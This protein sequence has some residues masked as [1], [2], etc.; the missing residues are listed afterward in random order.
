MG[1]IVHAL[2][3]KG[4]EIE[5]ALGKVGYRLLVFRSSGIIWSPKYDDIIEA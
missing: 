3:S 4:K 5:I 1:G 2:M